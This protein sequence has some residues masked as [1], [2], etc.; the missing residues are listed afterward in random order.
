M[1]C[2]CCNAPLITCSPAG[3][4]TE[5]ICLHCGYYESDSPAYK[6][7]PDLFENLVRENPIHFLKKVL[8]FAATDEILQRRKSDKDF[9]EP[10]NIFFLWFLLVCMLSRLEGKVSIVVERCCLRLW[11]FIVSF[12]HKSRLVLVFSSKAKNL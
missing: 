9:T 1:N 10:S 3:E 8:N 2:P 6:Q 11:W 4:F 12:S 7:H 5:K